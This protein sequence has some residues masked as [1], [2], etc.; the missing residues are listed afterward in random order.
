MTDPISAS[1][2]QASVDI[3][4][5]IGRLRRRMREVA[6]GAELSAAQASVLARLRKGEAATASALAALERVRPQS[7]ATTIASLEK[8]GLVARFP[9][10]ADGRRQV[11]AL[12]D[13][14]LDADRAGKHARGEWL[15]HALEESCSE[16][17]RQTVI[18]AA[19][20]LERLVRR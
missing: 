11:V 15:A 13:A 14:G 9:D 8:L 7:M 6:T 10:P 18:T 4:V 19:A 3:R 2:V 16:Q 1:A 12:T 17:E 20:V 5:A